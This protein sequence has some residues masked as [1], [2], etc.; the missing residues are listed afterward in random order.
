[1]Y[2]CTFEL[3]QTDCGEAFRCLLCNITSHHPTDV[4]QRYCSK[5]NRFAEDTEAEAGFLLAQVIKRLRPDMTDAEK[6][7]LATQVFRLC[8]PRR[9]PHQAQPS[10]SPTKP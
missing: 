5:C 1:M 7:D 4:V 3:I 6:V 2:T 8:S 9:S 10:W